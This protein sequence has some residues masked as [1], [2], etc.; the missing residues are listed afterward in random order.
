[1][2]AAAALYCISDLFT[3]PPLSLFLCLF[4]AKGC[5]AAAALHSIQYSEQLPPVAASL[6]SPGGQGDSP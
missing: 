6:R 2:K 5:R 1:M 3:G 4:V